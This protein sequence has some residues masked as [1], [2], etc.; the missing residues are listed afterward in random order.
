MKILN[1]MCITIILVLVLLILIKSNSSIKNTF[2][3]K[4]YDS[5]ISFSYFNKLYNEYIKSNKEVE[6]VFNEKLDYINKEKY[7]EGAKLTFS[8]NT[9]I[10]ANE[11]GVVIYKSYDTVVIQR[12]DGVNE[13]YSNI[14]NSN[15]KLYDYINKG[16]II[17][18][19]DEFL[20]I[21]YKKDGTFLNYEEFIK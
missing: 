1:K 10:H 20:Y 19:V 15:V 11:S 4:V 18:E 16:D 2:F 12:V 9:V 17:G 5:N 7:L 21:S 14:K 3:N 6:T 13:A 8:G